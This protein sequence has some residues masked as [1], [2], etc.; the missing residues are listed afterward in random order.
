MAAAN[1]K[2]LCVVF[3]LLNEENV[4]IF[5]LLAALCNAAMASIA[6]CALLTTPARPA[7]WGKVTSSC[8]V[9][10]RIYSCASLMSHILPLPS[11]PSHA[12]GL[13]STRVHHR[14][15]VLMCVT[16]S[17]IFVTDRKHQRLVRHY[18][19]RSKSF[20]FYFSE[21]KDNLLCLSSVK[22]GTFPLQ[23]SIKC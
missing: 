6:L 23:H 22:I 2:D 17:A 20:Y 19:S 13:W 3:F 12:A 18:K 7:G 10:W 11:C 16:S 5:K 21:L 8:V 15:V 1:L 14:S 9:C 4:C